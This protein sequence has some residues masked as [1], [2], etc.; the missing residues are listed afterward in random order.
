MAA[1]AP[2]ERKCPECDSDR[3]HRSQPR[4]L[5]RLIRFLGLGYYRCRQCQHRFSA[6]CGWG[7]K[8][9]AALRYAMVVAVLLL[10]LWVMLKMMGAGTPLAVPE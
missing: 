4:G 3:V 10:G 5:E 6:Y 8:E 1:Q 7:T 9:K 2:P